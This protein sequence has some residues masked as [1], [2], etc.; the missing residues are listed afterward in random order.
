[1]TRSGI[2]QVCGQT[3]ELMPHDRRQDAD[4][5]DAAIHIGSSPSFVVKEHTDPRSERCNGS[6]LAPEKIVY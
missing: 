3:V 1:M 4:I 5:D 6:L 2:C